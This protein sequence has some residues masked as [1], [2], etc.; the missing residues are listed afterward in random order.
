M[1]LPIILILVLAVGLLAAG[2]IIMFNL[3]GRDK[4]TI[5]PPRKTKP[6]PDA[7]TEKAKSTGSGRSLSDTIDY[8]QGK[9]TFMAKQKETAAEILTET[10]QKEKLKKTFVY[11]FICSAIGALT[12]LLLGQNIILILVLGIGLFFVPLWRLKLYRNK[13]R[14][15]LTSQLES[16]VTLVTTA[17]VRSGDIIKAVEE[18]IQDIS[19]LLRPYF[20]EFLKET[21]VNPSIKNCVR[22]LRD[23]VNNPTFKEW[24]ETLIRTLDNSEMR[25]ALMPI[26]QKYSDIRIVQEQIDLETRQA[27]LEY[28]IMMAMD[29]LVYPLIY[30]LNKEW[31]A[32]YSTTIGHFIIAFSFAVVL[33]CIAKLVD[34]SRPVEY[35]I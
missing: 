12:G 14:K 30:V 35:N 21:T 5:E 32:Y 31:W 6:E 34:I 17:Y 9:R 26:A 2:I 11:C 3:F 23:K 28:I 19:P 18:N 13:Y 22:N 4:K 24:C 8:Y 15:Y 29:V 7:D 20:E 25:E 27:I 33:F 10:G 16:S 1:N